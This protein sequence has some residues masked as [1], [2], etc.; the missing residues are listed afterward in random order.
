MNLRQKYI[1]VRYIIPQMF[2]IL[3]LLC[4]ATLAQ[5]IE[6]NYDRSESYVLFPVVESFPEDE[7]CSQ[8]FY[9]TG[10]TVPHAVDPQDVA[11]FE[12]SDEEI[13]D[14]GIS[15]ETT[16]KI[17]ELTL[18]CKEFKVKVTENFAQRRQGYV[19]DTHAS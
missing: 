18:A 15:E 4:Y 10:N 17:H 13:Y 14:T 12:S 8:G 11:L 16:T 5:Q 6:A 7:E 9:D 19:Y 2:Q 3:Q 1:L